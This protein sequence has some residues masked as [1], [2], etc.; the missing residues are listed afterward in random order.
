MITKYESQYKAL[1]WKCLTRSVHRNDRTGVGSRSIFNASLRIDLK[2][3][4]PLL[5]G[6]KMF[7]KT[8]DTEFE[9]LMNGE[10]NI[11][12]L[13]YGNKCIDFIF[14]IITNITMI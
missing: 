6:R 10:T 14:I 13:M 1:L 5:T 9:W 8:F 3:S 4:F 12:R 2:D 7:Q 11:K